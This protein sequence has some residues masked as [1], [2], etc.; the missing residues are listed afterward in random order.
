[1]IRHDKFADNPGV[2]FEAKEV[3]FRQNNLEKQLSIDFLENHTQATPPIGC[4]S[5]MGITL[6]T[7]R[8]RSE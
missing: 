1:L 6:M 5:S 2:L 7:V 4:I 3:I 8:G